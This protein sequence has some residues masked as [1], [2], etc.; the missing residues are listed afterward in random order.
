MGTSQHTSLHILHLSHMHGQSQST[1]WCLVVQQ[2]STEME[3]ELDHYLTA[4]H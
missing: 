2:Q 1:S 4:L 3:S